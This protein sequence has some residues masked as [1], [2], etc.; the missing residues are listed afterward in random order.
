MRLRFQ[1]TERLKREAKENV[2]SG[3]AGLR[4]WWSKKYKLPPNHGLFVGQS[5]GDLNLE[6]FEDWMLRIEEIE[7]A[8]EDKSYMFNVEQIRDMQR[9]MNELLGA[10]EDEPVV[11]DDLIDKWERELEAGVTP[12]LNEGLNIAN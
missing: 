6:M 7:K 8:L 5:V 2:Q 12:D 10:L 11:E 3:L 4:R 9:E 1:D